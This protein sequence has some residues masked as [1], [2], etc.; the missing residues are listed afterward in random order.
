MAV[1]AVLPIQTN[2]QTRGEIIETWDRVDR[3][4]INWNAI[5]T[6]IFGFSVRRLEADQN[7]VAKDIVYSSSDG[8]VDKAIATSEAASDVVGVVR[9]TIASAAEGEVQNVGVISI[10]GWSL[11]P[12][13]VYYL[14]ES[15][16]GAMTTTAPS[17]VG[18]YV[19]RLGIALTTTEFFWSPQPGILL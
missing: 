4:S 18:E 9:E 12:A 5:L 16:A 19:V 3:N 17:A 7:L 2:P 6:E 14:S 11:T 15:T 1:P 10:A 8:N 13:T